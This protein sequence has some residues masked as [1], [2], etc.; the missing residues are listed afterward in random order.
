MPISDHANLK[1]FLERRPRK[2]ESP[3]SDGSEGFHA[4]VRW[5]VHR[6]RTYPDI[7]PPPSGV[8]PDPRWAETDVKNPRGCPLPGVFR[9]EEYRTPRGCWVHSEDRR[10]HLK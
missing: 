10:R 2:G 1:E 5:V 6:R 3:R 7:A 8:T 4:G 9:C